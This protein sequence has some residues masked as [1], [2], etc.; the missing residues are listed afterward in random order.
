[1]T[2]GPQF[3]TVAR[4]RNAVL[5]IVEGVISDRTDITRIGNAIFVIVVFIV[6]IGANIVIVAH[7]VVVVIGTGSIAPVKIVQLEGCDIIGALRRWLD[8]RTA[9][10]AEKHS[11]QRCSAPTSPNPFHANLSGRFSCSCFTYTH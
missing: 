4:F 3:V 11:Y 8:P 5:V 7:T 10:K 6:R 2:D 9:T 1:M